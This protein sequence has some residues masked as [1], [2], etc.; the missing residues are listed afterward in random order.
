MNTAGVK[1]GLDQKFLKD[2]PQ[3]CMF[4]SVVHAQVNMD[5]HYTA[6]FLVDSS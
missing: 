4:S 3:F 2:T 6:V 1:G 5:I